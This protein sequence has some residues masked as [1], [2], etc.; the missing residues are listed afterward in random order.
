MAD[1]LRYAAL[2][3]GEEEARYQ[4]MLNMRSKIPQADSRTRKVAR[5]YERYIPKRIRVLR[6]A[7]FV[8]RAGQDAGST[9]TGGA[10]R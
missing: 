1:L 5:A 8:I 10:K 3:Q 4:A 2:D 9:S 6:H 7:T